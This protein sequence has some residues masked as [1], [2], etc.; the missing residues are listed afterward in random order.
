MY[1]ETNEGEELMGYNSNYS[2]EVENY[3]PPIDDILPGFRKQNAFAHGA[4][5]DDGSTGGGAGGTSATRTS[6]RSP[7]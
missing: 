3:P 6:R 7:R 4:I 5:L 1:G 2:V